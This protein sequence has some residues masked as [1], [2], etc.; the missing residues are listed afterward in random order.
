MNKYIKIIFFSS[1]ILIFG[2]K[3]IY[4]A[5]VFVTQNEKSGLII[6][7][8]MLDS[9]DQ[10]VNAVSGSLSFDSSVL[11][12]PSIHTQDSIINNW[13]TGPTLDELHDTNSQTISW[14]GIIPG[15]FAGVLSPFYEGV[16]PGRLFQ[17]VFTPLVKTQ[18]TISVKNLDVRANDGEATAIPV[19][20][21]S[22]TFDI[23]YSSANVDSSVPLDSKNLHASVGQDKSIFNN[24]FFLAFYDSV[25]SGSVDHYE[26]LETTFSSS[27]ISSGDGWQ[28]VTSP[29][30]LLDQERNSYIHLRAIGKDGSI[31]YLII[32]PS[33]T[34]SK[35][36]NVFR[37]VII[38]IIILMLFILFKNK[39]KKIQ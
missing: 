13:I 35:S 38:I 10:S 23:N 31:A 20:N 17:V 29:T 18:T 39:N 36:K 4:A 21:I 11:G 22:I 27:T 26:I 37:Y 34:I 8:V 5:S 33:P 24:R 2:Y 9:K 7:D 14:S 30:L 6:V 1:L 32:N 15:G 12:N 19:P 25:D 16:K 28:K 3:S